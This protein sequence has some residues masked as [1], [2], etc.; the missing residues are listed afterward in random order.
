M[1]L[2]KPLSDA[3]LTFRSAQR[4]CAVP[5][6]HVIETL[7]PLPVKPFSGSPEFVQGVSIIRGIPTVIVDLGRLL[8]QAREVAPARLVTVRVGDRQIGLAVEDVLGVQNLPRSLLHSL[9]PLLAN[10]EPRFVECIGSLEAEL[11]VILEAGR[12]LPP[13]TWQALSGKE[14]APC[15]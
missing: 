15:P 8:G 6:G 9:P 1:V 11:L 10:S 7:R 5:L 12:V 2:E 4:I 3:F 14:A 13:E